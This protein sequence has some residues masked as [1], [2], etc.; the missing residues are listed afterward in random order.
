M[1]AVSYWFLSPSVILAL[2]GKLKGWDRTKP[3]PAFDWKTATLD[4]VIPAK[5]EESSIALSLASLFDQDCRIRSVTVIDDASTDQT[6]RAVRRYGELRGREINLVIRGQSQGKTPAVREQCENSNADVLLV[7]DADTVLIHRTYVSRLIEQLFENA[8]VASA[9]GEVSPL[10]RSH[11]R[12]IIRADPALARIQSELGLEPGNAPSGLSALLESLTVIYR[13]SLYVFLHRILYDGHMKM[14]GSRLNPTG[15]AVAYRTQ[16]LRECFAYARPQMGD[17]LTNSEDIFIGHFFNWKGWRNVQVAGVRCE[18][19]EPSIERLP[20]QLYLWS[21]SFFQAVYYLRELP[22]SPF[23]KIKQ[24]AVG[25]FSKRPDTAGA[26]AG[27]QRRRIQEQY[28]APWGEDYTRR[29]G[30][31]VGWVDLISLLEKVTYPSLLLYFAFF[32]HRVFWISIG[33]EAIL[34]TTGVFIVADPG[35]RWKSAAMM[36]A[37][38]PIRVLSL[39]VDLLTTLRYLFDLGTGNRNWKK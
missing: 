14:F 28:R 15:C 7:L 30:R 23:K 5:N 22:L 20:R 1:A 34:A 4:V 39:G 35:S 31:S 19:I 16:R 9:C 17:N 29:F 26:G 38:T 37:A 13:T 21:S 18:S 6:A 36:L 25:L 8:G 11:R 24:W 27:A 12:A 32:N 10:I 3:T 33:L 2:I